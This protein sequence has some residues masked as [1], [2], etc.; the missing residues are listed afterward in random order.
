LVSSLELLE[1]QFHQKRRGIVVKPG[2]EGIESKA[3]RK[4]AGNPRMSKSIKLD[5]INYDSRHL[6]EPPDT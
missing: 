1:R 6:P 5:L 3:K 4:M 2:P